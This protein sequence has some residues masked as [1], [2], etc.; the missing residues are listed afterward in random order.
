MPALGAVSNLSL[1]KVTFRQ[2]LFEQRVLNIL[3]YRVSTTL[4]GIDAWDACIDLVAELNTPATGIIPQLQALQSSNVMWEDVRAQYYGTDSLPRPYFQLD[5]GTAGGRA[6]ATPSANVAA[7][8][9][10]RALPPVGEPEKGN[11]RL[12]LAGVPGTAITEGMLDPTY[13]ADFSNVC[14]DLADPFTIVSGDIGLDPV[15][16]T[17]TPGAFAAHPIFQCEVKPELRD[18]RRRTI[19]LGE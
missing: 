14:E 1:F 9:A 4:P 2:R 5:L 6:G 3:W 7:S 15:L 19:G 17:L 11:G 18:M 10:K 12:Q 13:M 8:I 16:V